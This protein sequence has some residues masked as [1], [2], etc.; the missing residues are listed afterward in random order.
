LLRAC[1]EVESNC[2]AILVENGCKKSASRLHMRDYINIEQSHKLSEYRVRAP[3]WSGNC[4]VRTPFLNWSTNKALAW[5]EAYN[6]AKHDRHTAFKAATFEH[7]LDA[8]CGCLVILSAQFLNEDFSSQPMRW[9]TE[10]SPADGMN[11]ALGGFF[12]IAFPNNWPADE[13]YDFNWQMLR[14]VRRAPGNN[15]WRLKSSWTTV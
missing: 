11:G 4:G 15:S 2:K 9:L 3:I 1:V 7:M 14:N 8:V 6:T 12:L 5:Y 13:R 10:S